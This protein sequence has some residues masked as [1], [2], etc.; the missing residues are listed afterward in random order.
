M[1]CSKF[2]FAGILLMAANAALAQTPSYSNIGR[3]PT[4]EEIQAWDISVGPDGKGL[5]VGHGTSKE[6]ADDFYREVR[7][8]PRPRRTR[9]QDWSAR[10][11]RNCRHRDLENSEAGTVRRWLLA[12]R[13][14]RVGLHS[15]RDAAWTERHTDAQRSICADRFHTCQERDHSGGR[16]FGSDDVT[17]S[18]D[19]QPQR[20][21]AR[22][23]CGHSG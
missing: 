1:R 9:R 17:Q 20:V 2:I 11:R 4:K 18:P 7:R 21:C 10:D 16:R 5:P 12:L 23:I 19:A 13:D 22:E 3:T 8:L 15:A 14:F 6:G